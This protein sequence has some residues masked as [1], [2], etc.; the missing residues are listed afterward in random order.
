MAVALG[1][2]TIGLF[3]PTNPGKYGPWSVRSEGRHR[4]T[5]LRHAE[6]CRHC[7]RPCVHTIS[8]DECLAA[9]DAWL[10]QSEALAAASGAAAHGRGRVPPERVDEA[11]GIRYAGAGREAWENA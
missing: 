6:P 11:Q 4:A 5:V 1:V 9:A 10:N 3:G 7:N 8:A 2:P